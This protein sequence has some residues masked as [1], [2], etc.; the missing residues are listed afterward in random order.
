MI[1]KKAPPPPKQH[2]ASTQDLLSRFH[3]LPAYNKYVRPSLLPGADPSNDGPPPSSPSAMPGT[4]GKGKGKEVVHGNAVTAGNTPADMDLGDG[5]DGDDDD[6]T[7]GKGEKKK[8]NTYKHLIKGIPGVL[9]F[10][11]QSFLRS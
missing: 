8:K 2:L 3:L 1:V 9:L 10:P 5:G 11:L 7:G 4:L 6:A